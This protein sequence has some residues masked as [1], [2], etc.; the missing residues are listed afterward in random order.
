M[1]WYTGS[2]YDRTVFNYLRNKGWTEKKI[3][4]TAYLLAGIGPIIMVI[5]IILTFVV[6][7]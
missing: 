3:N 6:K 5:G 1:S 4:R 2:L 7:V